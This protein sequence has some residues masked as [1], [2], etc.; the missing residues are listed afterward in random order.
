MS[1]PKASEEI[2]D[3]HAIPSL[4]KVIVK[5]I[6]EWHAQEGAKADDINIDVDGSK[7]EGDSKETDEA[8]INYLMT[9]PRTGERMSYEE[10]RMMYG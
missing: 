7:K 9:N 3:P 5:P 10:S 1:E 2:K 8:I 6:S 4:P